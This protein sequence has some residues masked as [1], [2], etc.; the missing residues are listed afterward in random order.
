MVI[1]RWH[2]KL[3]STIRNSLIINA[4]FFFFLMRNDR[5]QR[6]VRK[7]NIFREGEYDERAKMVDIENI[8]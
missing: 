6:R 4:F 1:Y 2:E 7:S 3:F 5:A 8:A